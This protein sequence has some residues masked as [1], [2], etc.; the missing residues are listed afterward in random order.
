MPKHTTESIQQKI[1]DKD[2]AGLL[3]KD[4][5]GRHALTYL[6]EKKGNPSDIQTILD[7]FSSSEDL[8]KLLNSKVK[9]GS[10][11]L[12]YAAQLQPKAVESLLGSIQ[13]LPPAQQVEILA[14]K[15]KYGSTALHY[16]ARYQPKAVE[17]L[18]ASIQTLP[19][20]QQMEVLTAKTKNDWTALHVAARYQPETVE[21]LLRHIQTLPSAQQ[22]TI[23]TG[24]TKYGWT[25]LHYATWKQPKA[26]DHFLTHIQ[27]LP[28]AQQMEVLT[29]KT[30]NDRT[31]L[32]LATRYQPKIAPSLKSAYWS[33]IQR[34]EQLNG[35]Q[36]SRLYRIASAS[37][38]RGNIETAATQARQAFLKDP[39]INHLK[40]IL[41]MLLFLYQEYS[42][43]PCI[44]VTRTLDLVD[45][46]MNHSSLDTPQKKALLEQ[47]HQF[48]QT[49]K[50]NKN[51]LL[52]K[53]TTAAM[54][55]IEPL[56]EFDQLQQTLGS[57]DPMIEL[58]SETSLFQTIKGL[59]LGST[60]DLISAI[61]TREDIRIDQKSRLLVELVYHY[62]L[63]RTQTKLAVKPA[64]NL[65][66]KNPTE[67]Y[68]MLAFL[69]SYLKIVRKEKA[70]FL[71]LSESLLLEKL[72]RVTQNPEQKTETVNGE[73]VLVGTPVKT[74]PT[75]EI[76]NL[77]Y[78]H[79]YH[80]V[81][82]NLMPFKEVNL[83]T[84]TDSF[85]TKSR[86]K[87]AAALRLAVSEKA[88][89]STTDGNAQQLR[90]RNRILGQHK[91]PV[92][93]YEATL[94]QVVS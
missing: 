18:L 47:I 1:A 71:K 82:T 88:L 25:A 33:I 81:R 38:N 57:C 66:M 53:Q 23:L 44:A 75:S 3:I 28:L 21:R 78:W 62:H 52:Y 89:P 46:I 80:T 93:K 67:N 58:D 9:H 72:D 35:E 26:A 61:V 17:S 22:T 45:C 92:E 54:D 42:S 8:V 60:P 51:A 76:T 36:R 24:K 10:A 90:L 73:T 27:R 55:Q 83:S 59:K 68:F 70:D 87:Q 4:E 74:L 32:H 85:F 6:L 37:L 14:A 49:D 29:A 39:D 15:N 86:G 43:L 7:L 94:G 63:T 56:T 12:H 41:N 84:M 31:A 34:S 19:L 20:A 79:L 16:A 5:Q 64:I 48:L 40:P 2:L 69:L 65:L 50:I 77:K 30:K 11:A 91:I 13:T